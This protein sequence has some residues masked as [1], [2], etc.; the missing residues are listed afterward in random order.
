MHRVPVVAVVASLWAM[1]ALAE[2]TP[3]LTQ[4][5]AVF[6]ASVR[7]LDSHTKESE[8]EFQMLVAAYV[9]A[10]GEIQEYLD[11][12]TISGFSCPPTTSPAYE[13]DPEVLVFRCTFEPDLGPSG[14]PNLSSVTEK[15]LFGVIAYCDEQRNVQRVRGYMTHGLLGP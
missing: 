3:A 5:A 11:F 10:A 6:T 13:G 8:P 1:P 9:P 12:M 14:E 7:A 2:L 4:Q 15:S